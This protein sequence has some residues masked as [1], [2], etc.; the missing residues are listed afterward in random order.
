MTADVVSAEKTRKPTL[1]QSTQ[2]IH[3][4]LV[5]T[6]PQPYSSMSFLN[7]SVMVGGRVLGIGRE[8]PLE[9]HQRFGAIFMPLVCV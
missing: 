1:N 6:T 8:S 9:D 3:L 2:R 7:L 4:F 5:N